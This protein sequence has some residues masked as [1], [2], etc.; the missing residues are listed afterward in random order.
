MQ[1]WVE[2]E[3]GSLAAWERPW[4]LPL[5]DEFWILADVMRGQ[6]HPLIDAREG[7]LRGELLLDGVGAADRRARGRF[8]RRAD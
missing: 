8:C 5:S 6:P 1:Q 2:V 3:F 7:G 4:G